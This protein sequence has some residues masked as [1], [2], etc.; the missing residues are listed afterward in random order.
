MLFEYPMTIYLPKGT[1]IIT[2]DGTVLATVASD[3]MDTD[4][5]QTS[6]FE[7]P[8]SPPRNGTLIGPEFETAVKQAHAKYISQ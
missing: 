3:I 5:K 1:K 2:E 4:L 6:Q 8:N 7:W